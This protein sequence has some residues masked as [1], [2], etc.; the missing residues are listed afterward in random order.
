[1]QEPPSFTSLSTTSGISIRRQLQ[2]LPRTEIS[3]ALDRAHEED[4]ESQEVGCRLERDAD[5]LAKEVGEQ[6]EAHQ[7]RQQVRHEPMRANQ[8]RVQELFPE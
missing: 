4:G 3:A 1:M 2:R 8:T 6:R 5:L 7:R